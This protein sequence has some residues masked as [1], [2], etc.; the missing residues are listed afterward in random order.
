MRKKKRSTSKT[1]TKTKSVGKVNYSKYI[2]HR[3]NI[4]G[5]GNFK[6]DDRWSGTNDFTKIF[7]RN[8]SL[9]GKS[10]P[11]K[12]KKAPVQLTQTSFISI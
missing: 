5:H 2:E 8:S 9:S 10:K 3:E 12:K 1:K 7:N 11:K 4:G 6:D